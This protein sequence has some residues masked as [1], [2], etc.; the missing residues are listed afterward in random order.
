MINKK[1]QLKSIIVA[2]LIKAIDS[3]EI[4]E[5]D[6]TKRAKAFRYG[7][8]LIPFGE[9]D[10]AGLKTS[11]TPS[12]SILGF[13]RNDQIP[14]YARFG[15]VRCV[16]GD[17]SSRRACTAISALSLS[18]FELGQVGIVRYVSAKD[19]D[20]KLAAVF[21]SKKWSNHRKGDACRLFLCGLP[22][23]DDKVRLK[24]SSLS[25]NRV[26]EDQ[27]AT[28]SE[29]I[30]SFMLPEDSIRYN[31]IPCPCLRSINKTV[32]DRAVDPSA[33]DIK[34]PRLAGPNDD[35][36]AVPSEVLRRAEN[37][38]EKFMM[39]FPRKKTETE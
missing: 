10:W 12:I 2:N 26:S 18:L 5:V 34:H 30:E 27:M 15:P 37:G 35:P 7:S 23:A 8:T 38:L 19:A 17:P 31:E 20:P 16:V 6:E 3:N 24:L 28:C 36:M 25:R 39:M 21:P 1:A 33:L 32:M 4:V 11:A 9:N 22:F 14:P 13:L 29:M